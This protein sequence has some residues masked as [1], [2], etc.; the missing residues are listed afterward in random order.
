MGRAGE[1]IRTRIAGG[2]QDVAVLLAVKLC[3][4]NAAAASVEMAG[5]T[6]K[7]GPCEENA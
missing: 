7:A 4:V 5:R 1:R 2:L 6:G 3:D